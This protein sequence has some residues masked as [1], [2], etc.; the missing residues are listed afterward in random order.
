MLKW[1]LNDGPSDVIEYLGLEYT[2]YGPT[3]TKYLDQPST[4]KIAVF[5]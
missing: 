2:R 1:F 5:T 4:N 3:I